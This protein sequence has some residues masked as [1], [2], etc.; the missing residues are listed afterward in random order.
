M[1]GSLI[2]IAIPTLV[3]LIATYAE[4]SHLDDIESRY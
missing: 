2:L 4:Q 3:G 1:I